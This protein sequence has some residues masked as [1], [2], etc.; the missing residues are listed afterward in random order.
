MADAY[1]WSGASNVSTSGTVSA[2]NFTWKWFG[3]VLHTV[4]LESLRPNVLLK[5]FGQQ[6]NMPANRG[7]IFHIPKWNLVNPVT[8]LNIGGNDNVPDGTGIVDSGSE[9]VEFP[10]ASAL[11]MNSVAVQIRAWGGWFKFTDVWMLVHEIPGALA[12]GV[13]QLAHGLAVVTDAH[14]RDDVLIANFDGGSTGPVELGANEAS[15]DSVVTADNLNVDDLFHMYNALENNNAFT[16]PGGFYEGLFHPRAIHDLFVNAASGGNLTL[17]DW[18][19]TVQGQGAF[20]RN[21]LQIIAGISI[22]KST[23][24]TVDNNSGTAI[25]GTGSNGFASSSPTP[26]GVYNYAFAPGAFAHVSL[27]GGDPTLIIQPFGSAGTKDPFKREM[28]ISIRSFEVAKELDLAK[29][30]VVLATGAS[31]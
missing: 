23:I 9:E 28:S 11:S 21:D 5:R 2:T 18:L 16:W 8:E 22:N 25:S 31:F 29:R 1:T 24:N 15:W 26:T 12:G 13:S 3:E 10:D 20:E 7:K 27:A 17:S 19:A 4:A 30:S 6:Y 14:I